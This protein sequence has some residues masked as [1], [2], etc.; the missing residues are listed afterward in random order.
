[1]RRR[2]GERAREKKKGVGGGGGGEKEADIIE[3]SWCFEPSQPQRI[4][5]G[6]RETFRKR[7]IVERTDT[8][9]MTADEQSEKE[10]SC[11]ENLWNKIQ[12]KGP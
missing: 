8:A 6:L 9:K 1:M 2:W 10:E 5:S 11:R 12:L 4:L 3:I 7:C